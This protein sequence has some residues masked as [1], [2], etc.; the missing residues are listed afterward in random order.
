[1]Y[2]YK[3]KLLRVVDGDTIDVDIDLG[4]DVWLRKQRIRLAGIDT[5]ESRT[6]NKVE[7][8]MGLR[9]K[10]FLQKA[11]VTSEDYITFESLGRGKFGRILGKPYNANGLDV[12]KMLIDAGLAVE[13]W[14]GKKLAKIK[15]DGTW[16]I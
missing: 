14:G 1:M 15:A 4:F 2:H 9:A 5:P 8:A 13:Y 10:E 3:A 11:L 6:R 12:C 16:G 7:K